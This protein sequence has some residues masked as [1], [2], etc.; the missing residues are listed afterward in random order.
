M[1]EKLRAELWHAHVDAAAW[2]ALAPSEATANEGTTLRRLDDDSFLAEGPNPAQATYHVVSR[3]KLKKIAA[4][5]LD[6]L[7]HDSLPQKGPGRHE[8]GTFVLTGVQILQGSGAAELPARIIPVRM[9][10]ADYVQSGHDPQGLGAVEEGRGVWAIHRA[11]AVM[12]DQ[13]LV[14]ELE[15]P[16]E[17]DETKT[18][19]VILKCASQWPSANIGRFRLSVTDAI[20]E[21][22]AEGPGQAFV[23]RQLHRLDGHKQ[24]VLSVAFST[25]GKQLASSGA[26]EKVR[27]WDHLVG[28]ETS[29]IDAHTDDIRAIVFSPDREMFATAAHDRAIKLWNAADHSLIKTLTGHSH[30]VTSLA[31]APDGKRLVSGSDDN[32]ARLWDIA[33]GTQIGE[34]AKHPAAVSA[35]AFSHDY[36]MIATGGKDNAIRL[37]SAK[38]NKIIE[39]TGHADEVRSLDFSRDYKWLASGGRDGQTRLWDVPGQRLEQMFGGYNGRVYG[40]AFSPDGTLLAAGGGDFTSGSVQLFDVANRKKLHTLEGYNAFVHSVAFSPDGSLLATGGGDWSVRVWRVSKGKLPVA[41]AAN[42]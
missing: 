25:D 30:N 4:V 16:L 5:R 35:V 36:Q 15:E 39:L 18:F 8:N 2:T 1:E 23:P 40:V 34:P 24:W 12:R 37:W 38:L 11:N 29:S 3:P 31:F 21:L 22:P 32:T 14:L 33:A 42:E 41:P 20:P 13:S 9:A 17:I 26:D 10:I 19:E 27:F 6:V 7:R 28:K